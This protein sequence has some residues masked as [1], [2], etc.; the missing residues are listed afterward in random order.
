MGCP[1]F[2]R[3]APTPTGDASTDTSTGSVESNKRKSGNADMVSFT[4]IKIW[5]EFASHCHSTSDFNNTR[6]GA[7]V[8]E[9]LRQHFAR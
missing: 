3:T 1:P 6:Y 5:S 4:L 8:S 2:N 9:K 7:T